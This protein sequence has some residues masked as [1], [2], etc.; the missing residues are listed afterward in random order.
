MSFSQ[1]IIELFWSKVDKGGEN[2]CW[3]WLKREEDGYG[4]FRPGSSVRKTKRFKAHRFAW[5]ITFGEISDGVLVCH[6]CDNPLC[7]NPAHLFLGSHLDNIRDC[8]NKGRRSPLV[9]KYKR[10]IESRKRKIGMDDAIQIRRLYAE[11]KGSQESI[12]RQFGITQNQVSSIVN[13]KAW[14]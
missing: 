12:G 2:D 6:K 10:T 4:S 5:T 9:G 13:R 1:R 3:L 14:V 7:V 11:G 8:V